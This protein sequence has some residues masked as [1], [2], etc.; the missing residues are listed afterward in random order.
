MEAH[1]AAQARNIPEATCRL[2]ALPVKYA[3]AYTLSL[4]PADEK[5]STKASSF[6][7][8]LE[9]WSKR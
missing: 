2:P 8:V 5:N 4:S 3:S 9:V 1:S 6:S 7:R